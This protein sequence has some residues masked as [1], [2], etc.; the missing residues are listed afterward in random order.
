MKLITL[1]IL[2]VML[3]F[4]IGRIYAKWSPVSEGR[5]PLG[6]W[7]YKILSEIGWMFRNRIGFSM[8]YDN[9]NKMCRKYKTNLYG[10]KI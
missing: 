3:S 1:W 4:F 2:T 7:R 10:D 6:W 8:Y 5:K 9:L